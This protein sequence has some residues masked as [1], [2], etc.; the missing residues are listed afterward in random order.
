MAEQSE[1]V[2]LASVP[3]QAEQAS[4]ELRLGGRERAESEASIIDGGVESA[5][6]QTENGS[7]AEEEHA[8]PDETHPGEK[9]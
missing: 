6:K 9:E 5:D 8:Q 4:G 1:G 3:E 2:E 7:T